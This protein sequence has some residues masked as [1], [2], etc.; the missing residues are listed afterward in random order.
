MINTG[1][2]ASRPFGI[3]RVYR[4]DDSL[5]MRAEEQMMRARRM[6]QAGELDFVPMRPQRSNRNA[7]RVRSSR[8]NGAK[9]PS[10]GSRSRLT[11]C[12]ARS[13]R[14]CAEVRRPARSQHLC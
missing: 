11:R 6:E 4:T 7:A 12:T 13:V 8:R 10:A 2:Y 9:R 1:S 3:A 5:T 14:P